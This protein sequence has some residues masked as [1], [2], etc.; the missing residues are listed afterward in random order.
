MNTRIKL[1][2]ASLVCIFGIFLVVRTFVHSRSRSQP[3]VASSTTALNQKWAE[4]KD[5]A[6]AIHLDVVPTPDTVN[7]SAQQ[8]AEA[9]RQS[10]SSEK[11]HGNPVPH[12]AD[13]F[14]NE[15][16]QALANC[17]S[18]SID[19]RIS[20]MKSHHIIVPPNFAKYNEQAVKTLYLAPMNSKRVSIRIFAKKGIK[21]RDNEHMETLSS[22][23]P[24]SRMPSAIGDPFENHLD[25]YE[26]EIPTRITTASGKKFVGDVG[27]LFVWDRENK[28]WVL[29]G[30][31]AHNNYTDDLVNLPLG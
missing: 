24:G 2:L 1:I 23:R 16:R 11:S 25:V 19:D 20:Y 21:I 10:I 9:L 4:V 8:I 18:G 15:V 29:W 26:A 6:D 3:P 7:E 12:N 13:N 14:I 22:T 5:E 17:I 31:V 27:Y 30:Y 28:T